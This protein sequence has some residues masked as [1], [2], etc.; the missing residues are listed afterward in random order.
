MVEL[1]ALWLP[2]VVGTVV[3]FI[4]G[5]V[6]WM[7]LPHHRGDFRR[8]PAEDVVIS[9]LRQAGAGPG[10]YLFP[11]VEPKD[12]RDPAMVAKLS[13]PPAGVVVLREPG[14]PD[15][16]KQLGQQAIYHLAITLLI[17]Y[18]VGRALPA[19]AAYFDV[20]R[21]V[22]AV[23]FLAYAGAQVPHAIWFGRPWDVVLRDVVD[24]AVWGLLTAGVFGWL[25]PVV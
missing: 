17:A 3:A 2:I 20:F 9:A 13:H 22:A 25:W 4:A 24:G 12:M 11:Y 8:L 18:A 1:G 7:V 10:Q 21:V 5:A 6:L 16:K 15:M 23:G 19:G 14:V